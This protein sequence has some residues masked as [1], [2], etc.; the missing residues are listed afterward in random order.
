MI[1][2]T[3]TNN[4]VDVHLHKSNRP[5]ERFSD[6]KNYFSSKYYQYGMK[7]ERHIIS[8]LAAYVSRYHPGSTTD[9]NISKTNV[10]CYQWLLT[11]FVSDNLLEDNGPLSNRFA[12]QCAILGDSAY[13]GAEKDGVSGL[14]INKKK[15]YRQKRDVVMY[16]LWS[17]DRVLLENL[18]GRVMNL[19]G[20]I[21]NTS[22]YEYKHY[23]TMFFVS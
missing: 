2:F 15:K 4:V 9:F 8:I 7:V 1:S 10:K 18:Y 12:S 5:E 22:T 19:C 21:H 16:E 6:V 14:Y 13:M 17:R 11:K 3:M 23:D 20:M